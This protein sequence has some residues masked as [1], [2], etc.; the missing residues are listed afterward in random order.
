MENQELKEL[1]EKNLALA[2]ETNLLVKK[3]NKYITFQK[4][5]SFIY[6]LIIVLPIVIGIIYLPPL[7]KNLIGQYQDVLNTGGGSPGNL[8]NFNADLAPELKKFLD[9]NR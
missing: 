8:N 5:V 1:L 7:L 9:G 2:Q 4:V 6:F 3:I